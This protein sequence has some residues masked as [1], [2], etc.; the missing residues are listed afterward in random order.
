MRLR[1]VRC[2]GINSLDD[3]CLM[4]PPLLARGGFPDAIHLVPNRLMYS[5]ALPTLRRSVGNRLRLSL[6]MSRLTS[7]YVD[8]KPPAGTSGNASLI[9]VMSAP[10]NGDMMLSTL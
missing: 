2:P 6:P 1:L 4:L 10:A 5:A 7:P 3:A 9:S 8:T